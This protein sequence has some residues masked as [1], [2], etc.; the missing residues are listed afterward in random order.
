MDRV[1]DLWAFVKQTKMKTWVGELH[2]M[3]VY[4]TIFKLKTFA[5]LASL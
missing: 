3:Y 2:A 1:Q 5:E 4:K